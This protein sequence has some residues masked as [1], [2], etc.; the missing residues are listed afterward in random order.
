[1]IP[2]LLY[3]LALYLSLPFNSTIEISTII[4]F[5]VIVREDARFALIFA[6][7]TGLLIDLYYPIR[8]GVNTLVYISLSEILIYLKKYLVLNPL[9]TIATFT[10]LYLVKTAALNVFISVHIDPSRVILTILTFFPILFLLDRIGFGI[11]IKEQ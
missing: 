4:V 2:Y 10:V 6:F 11:W 1:M 9:T 5:F 7:F 3:I 8:L